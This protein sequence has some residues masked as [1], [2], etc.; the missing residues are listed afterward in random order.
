MNTVHMLSVAEDYENRRLVGV[1]AT[2]ELAER[3]LL[4]MVLR[5]KRVESPEIEEVAVV[6]HVPE[7]APKDES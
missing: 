2:R 6:H 3:A 1:Y 5:N 7:A 4:G